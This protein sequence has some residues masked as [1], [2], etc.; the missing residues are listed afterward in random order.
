MVTLINLNGIVVAASDE[1][2]LTVRR[3]VEMAGMRAGLLIAHVS[4][5]AAGTNFKYDDSVTTK[6]EARI[7]ELAIRR[8][9]D[10]R[11]PSRIHAVGLDDLLFCQGTVGIIVDSDVTGEFSNDV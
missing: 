6:T 5:H 9:M 11:S 3:D 8:N 1:Y 10:I 2:V 4:Q 7:E